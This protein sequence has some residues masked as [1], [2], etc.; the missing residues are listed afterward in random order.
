MI[1]ITILEIA[2]FFL[3]F[4]IFFIWRWQSSSEHPIEATP[5]LRLAAI[6]AGLAVLMMIAL[7]LVESSRGGHEGEIY[8]PSRIVDGRVVPGRFVPAGEVETDDAEAG[9]TTEP[10]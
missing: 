8:I 3:P 6:G 1:R 5:T 10:Q 7:V 2:S 9:D 4:L